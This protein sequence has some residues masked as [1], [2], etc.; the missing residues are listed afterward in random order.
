MESSRQALA[1]KR[2]DYSSRVSIADK[3]QLGFAG[4]LQRG[5]IEL[6]PV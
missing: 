2:V 3:V 4:V 5:D 6:N 1:E